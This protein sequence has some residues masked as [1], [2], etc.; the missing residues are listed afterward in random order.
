VLGI[1]GKKVTKL[2]EITLG[3]I[4]EALAFSPDGKWLFVGNLNEQNV[5]V[6]K[7]EGKKVTDTGKPIPLPGRPG[8]MRG[9]AR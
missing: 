2:Q 1:E 5:S 6:L 4:T 9:R 7:V 3:P 8:A